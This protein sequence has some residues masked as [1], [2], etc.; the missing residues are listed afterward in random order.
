MY[1]SKYIMI[2]MQLFH[3]RS[4]TNQ[5]LITIIERSHFRYLS[6]HTRKK[7]ELLKRLADTSHH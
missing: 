6:A 5:K 3:S 4:T 2:K 1:E 7:N